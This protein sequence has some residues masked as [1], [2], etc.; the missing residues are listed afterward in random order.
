MVYSPYGSAPKR[1]S[2][3]EAEPSSARPNQ[4]PADSST[5]DALMESLPMRKSLAFASR[6]WLFQ[7]AEVFSAPLRSVTATCASPVV[8]LVMRNG[9]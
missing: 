8:T 7:P 5:S 3:S 4:T 1:A 2:G 9:T 6:M